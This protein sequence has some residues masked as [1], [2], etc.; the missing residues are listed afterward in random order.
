MSNAKLQVKTGDTVVVISG[1]D[2]GKK[3]QEIKQCFPQGRQD[4]RRRRGHGEE[5]PEAP[6]TDGMPGGIVEKEAADLRQQGYARV[7][8]LRKGHPRQPT[9]S[10]RPKLRK[11]VK[12]SCMHVSAAPA[13]T[14]DVKEEIRCG[15]TEG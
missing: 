1:I 5:A 10:S 7:P 14:T 11:S 12:Q 4:H 8:Q 13:L 15:Q 3:R 2:K 6:R 9:S